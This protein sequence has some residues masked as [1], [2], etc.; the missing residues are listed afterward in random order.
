MSYTTVFENAHFI[1]VDKA[2]LVLSVPGR[3]GEKDERPV[4]GRILEKDLA[5]TIYPV[6]RLDYEV[7]GLIM[8]A[9]NPAAHKAANAWFEKKEVHKTY[10]ALT[11]ALPETKESFKKGESYEWKCKLLRGKKRAYESPH[12]KDS[13]TIAKL[14]SVDEK[15]YFHWEM[16]PITGR[17]HQLR[18][19]LFRHG[20]PILGDELY[21]SDESFNGGVGI[22][23]RAFKIDFTKSPGKEKFLLPD[24][25]E[26]NKF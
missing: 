12:G 18:F 9:K 24:I 22:A 11:K 25:L 14:I 10:V 19:E 13:T 23:L 5:I 16:N 21:S 8:F 4:L 3:E 1:V 17:S 2:A 7:Q 15:G 20:H 6:H 26:I